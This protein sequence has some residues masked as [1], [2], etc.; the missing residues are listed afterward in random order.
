ATGKLLSPPLRHQAWVSGRAFS[1]DGKTIATGSYDKTVRLWDIATGQAIGPALRHPSKPGVA[2]LD[3]GKTLFTQSTV[4]RLFPVPPDLPDELERVA[5]W[6]EVITGLRLDRR[7]GQ[8]QILDNAVWLERREQ[9]TRLGGPPETGPEQRLDPIL[10]GPDPTARAR[11][12]VERKQWDAA[13]AA[14]DEAMRARP[15]NISIILERG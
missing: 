9:L 11:S 15:F 4:S 13:E 8:I 12:F 14:F 3:D 2:F 6:V 5:T 7:Q 10:F 1:P